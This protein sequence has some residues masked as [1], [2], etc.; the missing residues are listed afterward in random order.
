MRNARSFRTALLAVRDGARLHAEFHRQ[1]SD[2][3]PAGSDAPKVRSSFSCPKDS[4]RSLR[5]EL[6]WLSAA[7]R[8]V[9]Y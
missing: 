5:S 9:S 1:K 4:L 7:I 6:S 2:Q 3:M 8:S